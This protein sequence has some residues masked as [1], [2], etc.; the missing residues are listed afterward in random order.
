MLCVKAVN[1][2]DAGFT[3]ESVWYKDRAEAEA[4]RDRVKY[5]FGEDWD[6]TIQSQEPSAGGKVPIWSK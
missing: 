1:K 4:L 5:T 2:K 6:V 3:W